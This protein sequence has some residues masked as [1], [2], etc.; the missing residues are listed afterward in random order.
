MSSRRQSVSTALNDGHLDPF[1]AALWGFEGLPEALAT[2]KQRDASTTLTTQDPVA[3]NS[4]ETKPE[5]LVN[6]TTNMDAESSAPSQASLRLQ[7]AD[8]H[9]RD[10]LSGLDIQFSKIWGRSTTRITLDEYKQLYQANFL[11][12]NQLIETQES[13]LVDAVRRYQADEEHVRQTRLYME[14]ARQAQSLSL[15]DPDYGTL[16]VDAQHGSPLKP[17]H[18]HSA[19]GVDPLS[20]S[21]F[22]SQEAQEYPLSETASTKADID[23][24][25][26]SL[27]P[28]NLQEPLSETAARSA[29][30]S[31]PIRER[32][33]PQEQ[34]ASRM[35]GRSH[36]DVPSPAYPYSTFRPTA[37]PVLSASSHNPSF[38]SA[39]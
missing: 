35:R 14:H 25:T 19:V 10:T 23:A 29:S 13:I 34:A 4:L 1:I 11:A 28:L 20:P 6:G 2:V 32:T 17:L 36:A 16:L 18:N 27:G 5:T 9:G 31:A 26:E 37:P 24:L 38:P 21:M 39:S 7:G 12:I 30:W 33:F 8:Q 3:G 22:G 15:F